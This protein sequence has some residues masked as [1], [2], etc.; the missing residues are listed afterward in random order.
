MA[1]GSMLISAGQV[2][3]YPIGPADAAATLEYKAGELRWLARVSA[4]LAR[5][6]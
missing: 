4:D 3:E 5:A 1:L 6:L 2:E